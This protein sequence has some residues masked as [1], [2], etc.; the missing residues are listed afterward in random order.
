[1]STPSSR[2]LLHVAFLNLAFRAHGQRYR[3]QPIDENGRRG[4]QPWASCCQ[5]LCGCQNMQVLKTSALIRANYSSRCGVMMWFQL[6]LILPVTSRW[7]NI[8]RS[9]PVSCFLPKCGAQSLVS[10]TLPKSLL[11]AYVI[12]NFV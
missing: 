3:H 6:L 11:L 8:S 2:T 9:R 5:P 1:M 10:I 4:N 7:D 12:W